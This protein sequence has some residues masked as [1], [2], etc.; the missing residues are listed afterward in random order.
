LIDEAKTIVTNTII[1]TVCGGAGHVP[2]DCK[3]RRN[4]DGTFVDPNVDGSFLIQSNPE[5]Q[6]KLDCEVS[7]ED[8]LSVIILAL[9]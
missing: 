2:G 7:I 5:E 9:F 4:P 1:C 3:F 8:V 6:Q